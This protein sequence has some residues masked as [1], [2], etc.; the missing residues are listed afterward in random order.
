MSIGRR[1]EGLRV[2]ESGLEP[3][4]RVLV[5]GVQRVFFPGMPVQAQEIAMGDP[6]ASPAAQA[7]H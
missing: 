4:D 2:V 1:V 5:H 3:G 7:K 6:P